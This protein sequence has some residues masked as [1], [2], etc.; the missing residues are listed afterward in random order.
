[1]S[2]RQQQCEIFLLL[3]VFTESASHSCWLKGLKAPQA[4]CEP[5]FVH[6]QQLLTCA[7]WAGARLFGT[8]LLCRHKRDPN[9]VGWELWEQQLGSPNK[10]LLSVEAAR[11]QSWQLPLQGQ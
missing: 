10:G 9:G 11:Q 1:M 6:K 7:F 8:A 5:V 3:Q 2:I 4:S